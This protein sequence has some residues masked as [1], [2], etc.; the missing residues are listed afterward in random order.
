MRL[1]VCIG[2]EMARA[3]T[4]TS[5]PGS[6]GR[7]D[8]S[9]HVDDVDF[10]GCV[11]LPQGGLN[12]CRCV[13]PCENETEVAPSLRESLDQ[14]AGPGGDLHPDDAL[15]G[16]GSLDAGEL[17]QEAGPGDRKHHHPCGTAAGGPA[18]ETG[19]L[20][21]IEPQRMAQNDLFEG[22]TGAKSQHPGAQTADGTG[23][24]LQQPHRWLGIGG[25]VAHPDLGVNRALA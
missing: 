9:R 5:A 2:T 25:V 13:P 7:T 8:R 10:Q 24:H 3:S 4:P 20:A 11:R 17:D 21:G 1:A 23:R 18:G 16:G 15:D 12:Q 22:D 14:P 19:E 6:H